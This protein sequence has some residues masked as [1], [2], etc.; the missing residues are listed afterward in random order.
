MVLE[1][2]RTTFSDEFNEMLSMEGKKTERAKTKVMRNLYAV[3]KQAKVVKERYFSQGKVVY[4][5][6]GGRADPEGVVELA[7]EDLLRTL[8][9]R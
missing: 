4:N 7:Q 1:K 8:R 2:I 9:S 5:A 3:R 6:G